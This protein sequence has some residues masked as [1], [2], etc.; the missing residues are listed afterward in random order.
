MSGN[1]D[2]ALTT[3][4]K[5]ARLKRTNKQGPQLNE[6]S[7]TTDTAGTTTPEH[8]GAELVEMVKLG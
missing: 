4:S 1:R 7:N 3:A 5:S 6:V 8:A 2:E